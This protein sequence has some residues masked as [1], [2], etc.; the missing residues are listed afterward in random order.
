LSPGGSFTYFGL[1]EIDDDVII[2]RPPSGGGAKAFILAEDANVTGRGYVYAFPAVINQTTGDIDTPG[3]TPFKLWNW[4][5]MLSSPT[6]AKAGYAGVCSSNNI[7]LQGPCIDGCQANGT[8]ATGSIP[9][10]E[11]G[12]AYSHTVTGSTI[13]STTI[14]VTGLPDGLTFDGDT[15][16]ISGTPTTA[17]TTLVTVTATSNNSCLI[18]KIVEFVV[19]PEPE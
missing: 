9:S 11:V 13:D 17:G 5:Q 12:T 2:V 16:E 3:D 8:I 18:T 4:Q 19:T 14:D 1:S 6:Y 7:F 10:G 15:N